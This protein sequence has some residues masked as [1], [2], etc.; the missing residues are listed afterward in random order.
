MVS[1]NEEELF[2]KDKSL[3]SYGW[4]QNEEERSFWGKFAYFFFTFPFSALS[5]LPLCLA[6]LLSSLNFS[7]HTL[8]GLKKTRFAFP[9]MM[10]PCCMEV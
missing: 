1:D 6:L 7:S 8:S 10:L 9:L 3:Q 5:F 2:E 4:A